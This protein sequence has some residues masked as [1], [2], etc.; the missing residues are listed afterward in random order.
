M[1]NYLIIYTLFTS[2]VEVKIP[3]PFPKL[4]QVLKHTNIYL[5]FLWGE[6]NEK[7]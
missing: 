7:E 3:F 5:Q 1:S 6:K 2:S 4:N